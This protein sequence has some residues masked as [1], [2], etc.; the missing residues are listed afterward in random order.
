MKNI[1]R[2]TVSVTFRDR[3][4]FYRII[5]WLNSNIG[6]GKDNWSMTSGILKKITRGTTVNA[7]ISIY[8]ERYDSEA[9]LIEVLK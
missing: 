4:Q 2:N 7:T 5:K 1:A 6:H 9:F 3:S 8:N